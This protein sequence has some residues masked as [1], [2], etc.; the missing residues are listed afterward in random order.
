MSGK[1]S[2]VIQ[3]ILR[4]QESSVWQLRAVEKVLHNS[5]YN[6]D[7]GLEAVVG[8][9]SSDSAQEKNRLTTIITNTNRRILQILNVRY[10]KLIHQSA[11]QFCEL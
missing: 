10:L 4:H 7:L 11:K 5:K 1:A 3:L 9:N 6:S 2:E 8:I